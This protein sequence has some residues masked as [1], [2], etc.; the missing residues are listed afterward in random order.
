MIRFTLT[1]NLNVS[2]RLC[3]V[4]QWSV[5]WALSRTTRVLVLAGQ[6]VETCGKKMRTPLLGLAKSIYYRKVFK[7]LG[8]RLAAVLGPGSGPGRARR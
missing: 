3:P 8:I 7:V 4:V 5:H 1:H 2:I 6:G